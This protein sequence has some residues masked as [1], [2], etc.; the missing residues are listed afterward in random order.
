MDKVVS[1]AKSFE[2]SDRNDKIYY[3]SLTPL[4]RLAILF[5][6]NSRWP[7]NPSN[8]ETP[9]LERVYQIINV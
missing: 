9:R 5:E 3:Q 7:T 4:Q 8:G 1:I 6:L 2:A